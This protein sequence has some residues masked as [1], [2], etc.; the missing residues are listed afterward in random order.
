MFNLK[1][2]IASP[3]CLAIIIATIVLLYLIAKAKEQGHLVPCGLILG[4]M[5]LK[6]MGAL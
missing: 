2:F 6:A 3:G 4:A 5:L 1:G